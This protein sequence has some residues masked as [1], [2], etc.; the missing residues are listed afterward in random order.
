MR[1]TT[2]ANFEKDVLQHPGLCIVDFWAVW[3]A[4]CRTMAPVLERAATQTSID[5][6]K[7]DIDP[8]IDLATQY[9]VRSIP[10]LLFFK[11]GKVVDT[12]IGSVPQSRIETAIAKWK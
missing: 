6:F 7:V 3:C 4:P 1:E 8:E 12:I 10:T 5:V 11:G 2:T 9:G